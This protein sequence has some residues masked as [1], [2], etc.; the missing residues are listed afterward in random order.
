[1]KKFLLIFFVIFSELSFSQSIESLEKYFIYFN[2]KGIKFSQ[3]LSKNSLGFAEAEKLLSERAI[4]RRIKN[5]G[6]ENFITFEDVPVYQ[7][8]VDS[9]IK[10]NV[11]I[12]WKLKWLNA[13][14]CFLSYSQ[15]VEL[16]KYDFIKSI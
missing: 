15:L 13:V 5:S 14:S 4:N 6:V 9:L 2:D 10:K 8:Y 1:M 7:P 16:K 3:S 12:I 11:Q